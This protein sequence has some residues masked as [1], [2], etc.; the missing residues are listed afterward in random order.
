MGN[1]RNRHDSLSAGNTSHLNR[2]RLLQSSFAG[3]AGMAT[4]WPVTALAQG[5]SPNQRSDASAHPEQSQLRRSAATAIKYAKMI[6]ASTLSS[7]ASGSLIGSVRIVRDLAKEQGGRREA[8]LWF[9]G[10]RLPVSEAARVNAMLS[11]SA[12]SDDSDLRNVAHTGT[13]LT[14]VGWR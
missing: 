1:N 10:A 9:D 5:K 8:A 2:R 6:L 12:A 4:A 3:I 7:A 14:S 11:D 13:C